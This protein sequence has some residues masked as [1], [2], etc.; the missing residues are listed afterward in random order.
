MSNFELIDDY[1]TNR[2]NEQEKEAFEKQLESDPALKAD[3]DFSTTDPAWCKEC[4]G[5]TIEIHAE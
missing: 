3:V 2:L 1:L 4:K 5:R